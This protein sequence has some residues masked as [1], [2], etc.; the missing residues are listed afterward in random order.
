M[1]SK[2]EREKIELE[3]EEELL[4]DK[5]D[6]GQD[7]EIGEKKPDT[8]VIY[9]D[10]RIDCPWCKKARELLI[11][12]GKVFSEIDMSEPGVKEFFRQHR[13]KT[14]PQVSTLR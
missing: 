1:V 9:I 2:R 4:E 13:H 6:I 8:Y 7:W 10:R 14:V 12:L 11:S 3:L 5:S